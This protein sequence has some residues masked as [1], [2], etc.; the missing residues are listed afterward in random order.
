MTEISYEEWQE[1][2]Q[3]ATVATEDKLGLTKVELMEKLNLSESVVEKIFKRLYKKGLLI[4]EY[5][6]R[7][8]IDGRFRCVPV[9]RLKKVEV[10]IDKCAK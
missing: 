10:S 4:C 3:E 5:S 7:K 9:Y 2:L 1:A 6:R 8:S